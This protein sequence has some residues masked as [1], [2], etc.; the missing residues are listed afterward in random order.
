L[1][2]FKETFSDV[3]A[4]ITEPD[5]FTLLQDAIITKDSA[6]LQSIIALYEKYNPEA[7]K[8]HI[9]T[10][11][12][13][14]FTPL[15]EAII[16]KDKETIARTCQLYRDCCDK[17]TIKTHLEQ[18]DKNN[19]NTMHQLLKGETGNKGFQH[20]LK[21]PDVEQVL[22]LYVYALGEE[23][24]RQL[25]EAQLSSKTIDMPKVNFKPNP[26]KWDMD[27]LF[28]RAVEAEKDRV[29]VKSGH[30]NPRHRLKRHRRVERVIA[31]INSEINIKTGNLLD[32]NVVLLLQ[33]QAG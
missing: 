9:G 27:N 11:N 4:A 22:R 25:M 5:K 3:I 24:G 23:D 1:P 31:S 6:I 28:D 8:A 17:E 12:K 20:I 15:Q 18:L 26:G 32:L 14:G 19:F 2:E 33:R 16:T 29:A 13:Y 21:K 10:A 7:L 30:K